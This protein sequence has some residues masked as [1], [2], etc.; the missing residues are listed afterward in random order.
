MNSRELEGRQEREH[1]ARMATALGISP[2]EPSLLDWDYDTDQSD[3]GVLYG[4]IVTFAE[5][6]DPQ[7]LAKIAG[8]EEGRWVRI[9]P[10]LS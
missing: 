9:G 6:C 1:N 4:Y 3:D 10:V 7:I 2:E 5:G 8:L